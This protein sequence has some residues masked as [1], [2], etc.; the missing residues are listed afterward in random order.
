MSSED[1]LVSIFKELKIETISKE[2]TSECI[3]FAAIL[4]QKTVRGFLYRK[5][6]LPIILLQ[7]QK[8]LKNIKLELSN[9][10]IDGR[11]NSCVDE[12]NIVELLQKKFPNRIY[13]PKIRMWYDILLYDYKYSWIPVNIKT[14]TTLTNDNTGNLAMCVY[15]YTDEKLNLNTEKTYE[16]GEMAEILFEKLKKS[17]YNTN[18]KK[19]YFF[20]VINK[21]NTKDIIINSILGLSQLTSN[22]NNLPFQ[23]CWNK[24]RNYKF[25][26]ISN[27]IN[28]FIKCLQKPKP[29]WK[30][31]FMTNIRTL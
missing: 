24:N 20:L 28:L 14:T 6:Q 12:E 17:E 9:G 7:I 10:L 11:I 2:P 30:E 26:K 18:Y 16:N 31:T 5:T 23:V 27:K 3:N 25:E 4:I 22:I 29:S 13:T 21:N 15:S 8:F 19:D 1:S